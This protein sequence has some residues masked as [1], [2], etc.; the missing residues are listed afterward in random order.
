MAENKKIWVNVDG[1][2][3]EVLIS[4]LPKFVREILEMNFDQKQKRYEEN[5]EK[6]KNTKQV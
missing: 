6:Y 1:K 3:K 2:Q 4:S 5:K